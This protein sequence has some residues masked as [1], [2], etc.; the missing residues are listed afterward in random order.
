[1]PMSLISLDNFHKRILRPGELLSSYIRELKQLITQA[2]PDIALAAKEQL[3]LDQF[4]TG[5]PYEIS[6]QL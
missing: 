2:M 5:L 3:L 4:L 6:K 1:M